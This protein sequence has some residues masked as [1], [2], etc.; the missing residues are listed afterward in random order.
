MTD[1]SKF[2][3]KYLEPK[4]IQSKVDDLFKDFNINIHEP[5]DIELITEK[6]GLQLDIRNL[7]YKYDAFLK[8]SKKEIAVNLVR[9]N[10]ERY[11][12]RLKFSLAHELGHFILHKDIM[13]FFSFDSLEE[14]IYFKQNISDKEYSKFEWQANEFAGR[15]LVPEIIFKKEVANFLPDDWINGF[16]FL[17]YLTDKFKV[18]ENVIE[19]KLINYLK[20]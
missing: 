15:I 5:I 9:Y 10:D 13:E 8:V 11:Y 16:T 14:Y 2:R 20:G 3:C 7:D 4:D 18:S 1:F 19:I 17:N 6:V 12:N